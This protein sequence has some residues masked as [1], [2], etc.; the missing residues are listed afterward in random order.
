MSVVPLFKSF[1]QVVSVVGTYI[2]TS[3]GKISLEG[4]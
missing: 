1:K 2:R 3:E 4:A